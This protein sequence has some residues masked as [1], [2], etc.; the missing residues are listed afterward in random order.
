MV[1]RV[2]CMSL[3]FFLSALSRSAHATEHTPLFA[4]LDCNASCVLA[5]RL[6]FS[7][8]TTLGDWG[9]QG[10]GSVA[11]FQST[12]RSHPNISPSRPR[13]RMRGARPQWA[14]IKTTQIGPRCA[15]GELKEHRKAARPS[16]ANAATQDAAPAVRVARR[17]CFLCAKR[18]PPPPRK[19]RGATSHHQKKPRPG[20]TR[21]TPP[22]L[23]SRAC[24]CPRRSTRGLPFR[25]NTKDKERLRIRVHTYSAH[26]EGKEP[27]P[28]PC[29][30]M[31]K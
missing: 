2:C 14:V 30:F 22:D 9:H 19:S 28:G 8:P 17:A 1:C 25:N 27:P 5:V 23:A 3:A 6:L 13:P 24:L 4:A 11:F 29:D 12:R 20:Q 10:Y 26:E 7:I 21:T 31:V 16:P 18:A 15:I